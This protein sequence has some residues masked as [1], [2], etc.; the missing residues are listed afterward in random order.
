MVGS[1]EATGVPDQ[2]STVENNIRIQPDV[3]KQNGQ[4]VHSSTKFRLIVR[5]PHTQFPFR[6][7]A[8]SC[9]AQDNV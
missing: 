3:S 2:K 8:S 5:T 7:R 9:F 4:M 6:A 1:D